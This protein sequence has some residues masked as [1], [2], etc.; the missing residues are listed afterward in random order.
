MEVIFEDPH[1]VI[2]DDFAHHPTA[3]RS[4][5]QGL[6]DAASADEIIAIIEPRT[7][8]MSLGTLQ[9]DLATCCAAADR[10]I[11]FR[12][13]NIKWDLYQLAQDC[14]IDAR[15]EDDIER[16]ID[17][18]LAMP[19]LNGDR[20]RHL[21]I[22]SNGAFGGIYKNIV[23]QFEAQSLKSQHLHGESRVSRETYRHYRCRQWHRP[24]H[25]YSSR[26]L[27]RQSS[28]RRY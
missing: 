20:R 16:L 9:S 12:G 23:R 25:R 15:V 10:V 26:E 21:V 4:T 11:W 5:L 17:S 22:M 1:T 6:R 27:W 3:I 2:Y 19:A 13:D 28:V 14:V 18:L 8:T 24:R 7:H